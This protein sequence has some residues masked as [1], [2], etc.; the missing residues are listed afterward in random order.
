ME[1]E[2]NRTIQL[3]FK[4][5]EKEKDKVLL[6]DNLVNLDIEVVFIDGASFCSICIIDDCAHTGS[7]CAKQNLHS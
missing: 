1:L 7:I 5:F 3:T 2:E 4:A 6:H